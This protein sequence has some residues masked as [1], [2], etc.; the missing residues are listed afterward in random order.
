[1]SFVSKYADRLWVNL[2]TVQIPD[3]V[4]QNTDYIRKFGVRVTGNKTYDQMIATDFTT[5]MVPIIKIVEYFED[6]VEVRIPS[7]DDMIK[8]HKDTEAY[9]AE[10]R[11]HL[12]YSVNVAA[13]QNKK[14]ILALERFSKTIYEKAKPRE[15]IDNLFLTTKPTL[16]LINPLQRAEM[17]ASQDNTKPDYVEIGKLVRSKTGKAPSRF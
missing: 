9:L 14:L 13:N 1:M 17:E 16:G 5:I 6:G 2:Y 4:T 15:V 3:V 7:R 11:D 12:T 10:W 8:M